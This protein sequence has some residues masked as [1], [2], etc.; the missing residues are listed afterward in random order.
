[1]SGVRWGADSPEDYSR[2]VYS[3][4]AEALPAMRHGFV[5]F[6]ADV[7]RH[8]YYKLLPAG[9]LLAETGQW[10]LPEFERPPHD[11]EAQAHYKLAWQEA[12][13]ALRQREA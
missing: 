5:E 12:M 6:N 9:R 3:T 4:C 8:G 10:S 11:E 1:M 7:A 13:V 2:A